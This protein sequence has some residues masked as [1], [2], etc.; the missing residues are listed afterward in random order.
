MINGLSTGVTPLERAKSLLIL[1]NAA[2][3]QSSGDQEGWFEL[4]GY[5]K[6]I[7]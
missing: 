4:S 6:R 2:S 1:M 3:S 5:D 7:P